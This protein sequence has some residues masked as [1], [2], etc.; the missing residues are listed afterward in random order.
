[1]CHKKH[2][3]IC[4]IWMLAGLPPNY[5][6]SKKAAHGRRRRVAADCA[7]EYVVQL[8]VVVLVSLFEFHMGGAGRG[9][10]VGRDGVKE[11]KAR[12]VGG[13]RGRVGLALEGGGHGARA[14]IEVR[15]GLQSQKELHG[16][17]HRGCIIHAAVDGV[18]LDPGG[19]EEGGGAVGIHVVGTVLGV[20]FEDENGRIGPKARFRD[21]LDQLA[22][23][24][25]VIGGGGERGDLAGGGAGSVVVGEAHY[26]QARHIA[27]LLIFGELVEEDL[28]PLDVG[29]A[30]VE[31]AVER[32]GDFGED[33]VAHAGDLLGAKGG[34]VFII[35]HVA[36]VA[37]GNAGRG[38]IGPQV[39]GGGQRGWILRFEIVVVAAL[40]VH[41]G[42]HLL[43]VIGGDG[44]GGPVLAVGVEIIEQDEFARQFVEVGGGVFPEEDQR[45]VAVAL[46]HVAQHLVVG[47]VF[48]NDVDDVFDVGERAG[49]IQLLVAV[50]RVGQSLGGPGVE[51]LDGEGIDPRRGAGLY[52]ADVLRG[53]R[54]FAVS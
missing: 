48:L 20:V 1:M 46:S 42:P 7:P 28:G 21:A 36:E 17:E 26:N 52:A 6:S 22:D 15:H 12:L 18:V 30:E 44:R 9:G 51:L 5:L 14:G 10:G 2:R 37:K 32:V 39:A 19:D 49:L 41:A 31:A 16:A 11:G 3:L 40:G 53:N 33:G 43:H 8:V 54:R 27:G 35:D 45:R 13:G 23:G 34:G 47:A 38:G 4:G 29:I 24:V 50:G 25:V